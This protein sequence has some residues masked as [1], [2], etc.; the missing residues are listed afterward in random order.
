AVTSSIRRDLKNPD[1]QNV[2]L[3]KAISD[4]IVVG[5]NQ[6][7]TSVEFAAEKAHMVREKYNKHHEE[8]RAAGGVGD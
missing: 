5:F 7:R 2:D 3:L 4:A 6:E 8:E 1:A